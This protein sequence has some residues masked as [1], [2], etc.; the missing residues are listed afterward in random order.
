MVLILLN[1]KLFQR[2]VVFSGMQTGRDIC[3]QVDYTTST[4][5]FDFACIY[6]FSSIKKRRFTGIL[7]MYFNR[8]ESDRYGWF[9]SDSS[10]RANLDWPRF[11]VLRFLF[12]LLP[13][14]KVVNAWRAFRV[15]KEQ[16][17]LR[18]PRLCN[19]AKTYPRNRRRRMYE[20]I[21]LVML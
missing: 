1:T 16:N 6:D 4:T 11:L 15:I 7:F 19:S 17:K 18:Q 14:Q 20:I 10:V 13:Q 5:R 2:D 8:E 21:V 9:I 12:H 3:I